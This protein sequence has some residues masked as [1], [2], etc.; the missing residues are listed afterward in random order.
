MKN[1]LLC[2]LTILLFLSA[3]CSDKS[4]NQSIQLI[5]EAHA[6]DQTMT[7]DKTLSTHPIL[8]KTDSS[9][10]AEF[11]NESMKDWLSLSQTEG[12]KGTHTVEIN[13]TT[14]NSNVIRL[15]TV[16]FICGSQNI[17]V[18]IAQEGR[19]QVTIPT[20]IEEHFRSSL[21]EQHSIYTHSNPIEISEIKDSQKEIWG[22]W[23]ATN[24]NFQEEKL[25]T[26]SPLS[27]KENFIWNIPEQLEPN[28]KM[29]YYYGSKG[30][31]PT[32]GYPLFLYLHG[33]GD[34][35][36][37]WATGYALAQKFDDSPSVYFVPQIPNIGN[38]Y[39]WYQKGKQ[40]IWERLLR[41]TFVSGDINPN[42]VY[43][44]GISEGG[45]GSQRLASFYADYLAG[46]GPMAGGEPLINAPVENCSNIAFSLRTGAE[47]SGFYRNKLTQYTSD[48]FKDF[49][50][51]YPRLF[52]HHI[53]LIPDMGHSI[54]YSPTT[55]WLK[56]NTRNPYPKTFLWEDFPMDGQYRKGFY[57]LYI[58]DRANDTD[59]ARTFYEFNAKENIIT[60]NVSDIQYE[61]VEKD[62]NWGILLKCAKTL[63]PAS[64]GKIIVY[65]NEDLVDLNKEV[66]LLVNGK[67]IFKDVLKLD[68]KHMINSCAQFFDPARL[69]PAAIE[70]DLSNLN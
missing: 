8:F 56:L 45:Y 62:P 13:L 17:A 23:K 14:N 49:Q 48:A 6:L 33:S 1:I 46:A 24:N 18:K 57:N 4:T 54:D 26:L 67:E 55:P 21:N 31:A 70:V 27:K 43:F 36:S 60:L 59:D 9:W 7:F 64:K 20:N 3:A 25:P 41:L 42:R 51:K 2:S 40:Y 39:R 66:T 12:N 35:N 68:T 44:F 65:L 5:S 28:A 34:R 32:E 11:S 10:Y 52:K 19:S 37:E 22:Y 69:F 50:S 30:N 38:Y 29:P 16:K 61:V 53:N 58:A 15:G 47:D 63:T